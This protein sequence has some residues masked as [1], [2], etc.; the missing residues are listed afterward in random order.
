[1]LDRKTE[2]PFATIYELLSG[3]EFLASKDRSVVQKYRGYL[4][5]EAQ[6]ADGRREFNKVRRKMLKKGVQVFS[7]SAARYLDWLDSSPKENPAYDPDDTGI[8]L[9]RR[10]LLTLPAEE[11]YEDLSYNIFEN[12]WRCWGQDITHSEVHQ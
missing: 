11:N 10:S 7:I 5:R 3:L 4:I 6:L 2:E 1:M 9:L 8:P 12:T